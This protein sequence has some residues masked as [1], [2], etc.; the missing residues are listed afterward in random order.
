MTD[1]ATPQRRPIKSYVVRG[2]RL[3]DA[4][5]RA[6][7]ELWPRYGVPFTP[8]PLD[9]AALFGRDAACTLEIGFGN[10]DNLLAL[11]TTQPQC[12][13]IGVE[14]HPPGVG[15]LLRK[16]GDAGLT[17]LKVIQHDAVEVLQQQIA[18]QSLDSILVLFPD[19]WHKK[20]HNK[21]RLVNPDFAALAASRL[22]A[23]GTLQLATDWQPYAEAMLEVLNPAAGLRNRAADRRFVPRNPGRI[24]TRFEKRGERL[25]HA[26]HDLCFE[27]L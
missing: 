6:L 11:A 4:Q 20:R 5:Q 14:V 1:E 22:K 25:G 7:D 19:P 15:H 12:N 8:Q 26:V 21:R 24:L 23:G 9:L 13:F 10:G 2:G 3:T 16:A 18:A 27:K 17:N